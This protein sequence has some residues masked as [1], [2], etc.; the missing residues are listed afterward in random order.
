MQGNHG[1]EWQEGDEED[2]EEERRKGRS[3]VCG[4]SV[5]PLQHSRLKNGDRLTSEGAQAGKAGYV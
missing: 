5:T 2:E 1:Q 4:A 3:S